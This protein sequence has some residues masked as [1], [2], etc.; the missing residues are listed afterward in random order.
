MLPDVVI[1]TTG[2]TKIIELCYQL[3]NKEII[4]LGVQNYKKIKI[5]TLPILRK[6]NW[7]SG[8]HVYLLEI[9]QKYLK[10]IKKIK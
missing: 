5:A 4:L 8:D 1:D 3:L 7:S 10:N 9:F 2:N 6:N